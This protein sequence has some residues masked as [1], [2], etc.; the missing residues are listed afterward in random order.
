MS[1]RSFLT[2]NS[3]FMDQVDHAFC[4]TIRKL[5]CRSRI[6]GVLMD[7]QMGNRS[8]SEVR[9]VPTRPVRELYYI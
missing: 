1:R 3:S 8:R 9:Y 7:H 4:A 2:T 5:G 6:N